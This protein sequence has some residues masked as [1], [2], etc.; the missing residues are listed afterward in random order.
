MCVVCVECV[1]VAWVSANVHDFMSDSV[2]C[3]QKTV[4]RASIPDSY[5]Q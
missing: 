5:M 4:E 2:T 3:K 1:C